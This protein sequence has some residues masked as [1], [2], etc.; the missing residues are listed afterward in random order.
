MILDEKLSLERQRTAWIV[1]IASFTVFTLICISTPVLVN[2]YLQNATRP[3]D[4]VVQANQGTVGIDDEAGGRRAVIVGD[5]GQSIVTGEHVLTGNTATALVSVRPP[6]SDQLLASFQ[7]Y[8][9]TDFH[10]LKAETPRFEVSGH[11]RTLVARLDNGRIRLNVAEAA[12]R[13]FTLQLLTPQGEVLIAEPGQYAVVVRSEDKDT[14]VTVRS[15]KVDILAAGQVL[16]LLPGSR[17]RIPTGSSPEGPLGT[18]RNLIVNGDFS[19]SREQWILNPWIVELAAQPEGQVRTLDVGGEPRLNVT[20]QGIGHAEV[21]LR[22]VINQDVSEL[23]SLRLLF[24]FRILNETLGVCGVKGSECPLFVR[25]NY[26]DEA[27]A[28]N[29]WQQGFYATGEVDPNLT[30]DIC[31]TCAMVQGP[32]IRVPAQQD[33]FYEIA[34]FREELARHGRLPPRLIESISLVF[35]GHGFEVEVADVALLA[36]E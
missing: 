14:Q 8:S 2:A 17:G 6:E 30:P 10:L 11:G 15:G 22:Q 32:H 33:Y 1:L 23:T 24:T 3:L 34:D 16:T 29:T 27:G 7:V 13:P 19:R 5:T 25:V 9:N 12:G 4:V 31:T 35:S 26:V 20:R 18:E 28:S 36:E 21:S